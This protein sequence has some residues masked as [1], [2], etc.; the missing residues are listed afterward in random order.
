M[1]DF[2]K[3]ARIINSR[4]EKLQ[5]E[6]LLFVAKCTGEE[7]YEAYLRAFPQGTNEIF[8]ERTEHDCS[9]CKAWL[10]NFGHIIFVGHNQELLTIWDDHESLE[11]PYNEVAKSLKTFVRGKGVGSLFLVSQAKFNEGKSIVQLKGEHQTRTFHHFY[12]SADSKFVSKDQ[13]ALGEYNTSLQVLQK[14]YR[15]VTQDALTTVLDLIEAKSLYRGEEHLSKVQA[16][17]RSFKTYHNPATPN[18]QIHLA[19]EA[20]NFGVARFINSVI[21][22]LVKDLSEGEDLEEAVRSF[23]QKVAPSNYQRTNQLITP[24]MV[25]AAL[26]KIDSL[27]VNVKRRMAN[28]SDISLQ[29]ILWADYSTKTRLKDPLKDVLMSA[30]TSKAQSTPSKGILDIQIDKFITD[31]L[32]SATSM[33]LLLNPSLVNNFMTLT[34]VE[35][36]EGDTPLFKW[37]NPFSWAYTGNTTDQI[38]ERVKA[39]GGKTEGLLRFSL[40]WFNTDDLDLHCKIK[41]KSYTGEIYYGNKSSREGWGRQN[42][43]VKGTL[44][45]DMNISGNTRTAVENIIFTDLEPGTYKV[46][47]HNFTL[48]EHIDVGFVLQ[49]ADQF[50]LT[51]YKY[52]KKVGARDQVTVLTATVHS[53]GKI[54]YQ[55]GS[56]ITQ[57]SS[58]FKGEKWGVKLD[59]YQDVHCVMYSPNYWEGEACTGNKHWFFILKEAKAEEQ[60]RG[61]FNE[62]LSGALTKE[63]KVFDVLGERTKPE[64]VEEQLSGI[65]ISSTLTKQVVMEVTSSNGKRV[66]N[67]NF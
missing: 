18:S 31:V 35:G 19:T 21:G 26:K 50:S 1:S 4:F 48:R 13:D 67:V 27:G 36:Q 32:P 61:I 9:S 5:K 62:Y 34:T 25:E 65:G 41:T 6:Q 64:L 56:N 38:T 45:V 44:D 39:A 30:S 16:F 7:L 58:V 29:N 10:R 20:K 15:T 49:V 53:D 42:S 47:V 63:R 54:T 51:N 57:E 3:F 23:E 55:L 46:V 12:G 52:N 43:K 59:Q 8:R 22:T 24:K 17:Q 60:P 14:A 66:Y 40:S 28:L 2:S 33:K 11:Y 37:N